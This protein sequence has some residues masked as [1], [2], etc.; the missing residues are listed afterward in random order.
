[1][2][3]IHLLVA[4]ILSLFG[5][6][7]VVIKGMKEVFNIEITETGYYFL[8]AMLGALKGIFYQINKDSAMIKSTTEK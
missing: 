8:F 4:W 3:V 5:F 7:G 2:I 1:M 6:D